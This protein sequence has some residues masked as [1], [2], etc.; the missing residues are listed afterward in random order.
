MLYQV[1]QGYGLQVEGGDV[2][3]SLIASLLP[4]TISMSIHE[5]V[6]VVPL[7]L[8]KGEIEFLKFR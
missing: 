3:M 5:P 6:A 2:R 8:D 1:C 7:V 4:S